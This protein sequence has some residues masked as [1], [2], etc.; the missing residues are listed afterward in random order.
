MSYADR[1]QRAC[2]GRIA[3]ELRRLAARPRP[4][5]RLRA[6]P[7]QEPECRDFSF[8]EREIAVR[9]DFDDLDNEWCVWTSLHLLRG[10]RRPRP[11]EWVYVLDGQGKG[12]LGQVEAVHGWM[13]RVSLDWSTWIEAATDGEAGTP[14]GAGS[15]GGEARDLSAVR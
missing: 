11:S 1:L 10:P 8:E 3:K 13:A 9:A 7:A 4:R 15:D 2:E 6:R 14:S 12:C 5:A